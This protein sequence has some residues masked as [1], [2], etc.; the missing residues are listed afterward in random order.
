[1]TTY[2]ELAQKQ[3]NLQTKYEQIKSHYTRE[4]SL[5]MFELAA[6][7]KQLKQMQKIT[8]E[9]II[10]NKNS[11]EKSLGFLMNLLLIADTIRYLLVQ[12]K[13]NLNG[14]TVEIHK[15]ENGTF[16]THVTNSQT[17]KQKTFV[18]SISFHK[19]QSEEYFNSL[20]QQIDQISKQD[21][22][23]IG[24]KH[25]EDMQ[26]LPMNHD[27]F[28]MYG[29]K[30][31]MNAVKIQLSDKSITLI[32]LLGIPQEFVVKSIVDPSIKILYRLEQDSYNSY[33]ETEQGDWIPMQTLI[34]R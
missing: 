18:T 5:L 26:S 27:W 30:D 13:Q 28:E 33:F 1:M 2:I 25:Q 12:E 23:Y 11:I 22:Q 24:I 20:L 16:Y 17:S 3:Y 6:C 9:P 19:N 21:I 8:I 4:E 29:F 10:Q 34:Q 31:A 14:K 7:N 15:D 32:Q